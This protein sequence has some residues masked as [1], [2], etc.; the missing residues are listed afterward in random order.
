MSDLHIPLYG[1]PFLPSTLML[2][3][4]LPPHPPSDLID[5]MG[6]SS[7]PLIPLLGAM[8][9]DDLDNKRG[10]GQTVSLRRAEEGKRLTEIECL[11]GPRLFPE[12]CEAVQTRGF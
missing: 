6:T 9:R 5:V 12:A 8:V 11:T 3:H 4:P 7:V 2:T 1:P 10:G